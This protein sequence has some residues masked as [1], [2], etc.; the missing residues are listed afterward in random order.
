MTPNFRRFVA[1]CL[2]LLALF[3]L[4]GRGASLIIRHGYIVG[5]FGDT[6]RPD[7]TYSVA[8]S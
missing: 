4:I 1:A 5:E 7:P 8:K 3:W 6:L 2:P